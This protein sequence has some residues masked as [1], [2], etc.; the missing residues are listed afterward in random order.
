MKKFIGL[1]IFLACCSAYSQSLSVFDVDTSSFPIMRAKFLAFDKDGKPI[2]PNIND[3]YLTENGQTQTVLNVICPSL[4]PLNNVSIALSID[5]SS[6]M[7]NSNDGDTPIELG[8]TSAT[9]LCQSIAMPPSEFALQ[10]CNDRADILQ[11]FTTNK[12][13]ILSKINPITVSGENDFVEQLSNNLTG[14]LNIAKTGKHKRIAIIFTDA[15]GSALSPLQLQDC[16]D[17]CAKYNIQFFAIIYNKPEA[18]INGIKSS[19]NSLAISSGG[20]MFD[21]I[22]SISAAK[23]LAYRLQSETQDRE[24]CKIEWQSGNSC[25]EG[26]TKVELQA[27]KLVLFA[28][29]SYQTPYNSVAKLEFQPAF[30]NL[31]NLIPGIKKDTSITVTAINADFNITNITVSNAAFSIT[32][33]SFRL[34]NGETKTLTVSFLP[35]KSGYVFCRFTFDNDL[36]P[37]QFFGTGGFRSKNADRRTLKLI[38]PN[39]GEVFLVGSDTIIT[40]EGVSPDEPVTIEYRTDDNQPWVILTETAKGLSYKFHVPK[41]ASDKYLARVTA[42]LE[43][44]TTNDYCEIQICDQIWMCNNLN[45]DTYRNGDPIP[46]V[47]DPTQ[48]AKLTT[49]AWC[50]YNNDP[51]MG[52]IYGKLYNWYAV[53]DP[54]GLAPEGWHI[55]SDEEWKKL[56]ICMG[57]SKFEADIINYRGTDE[58]CK[59]KEK[60]TTH[61][62]SPNENAT[63]SSGFTGLPG[64]I[65]VSNNGNFEIIRS[66]GDWWTT[67]EIIET[68]AWSHILVSSQTGIYRNSNNK[69]CGFSVRCVKN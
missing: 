44:L 21:G 59:L 14:L 51:A 47:T 10:I 45:V 1:F 25:F 24:P 56:E 27:P 36:C 40:W 48:W 8:K 11:D 38:Q 64:G 58:G 5:V 6:S 9:E 17:T 34:K 22:T 18:E 66:N 42:K 3:F 35:P 30:V 32:P 31:K 2:R 43:D 65:R 37:T 54:R 19:L 16:I 68:D 61:W 28:N 26:M 69:N 13:K 49:G 41:I 33:Q 15:C 67:T 23:A 29:T 62:N 52:E 12:N 63:N 53:N 55:P 39:G 60:G 20:I 50:Y 46:E 57:M 7:S 4:K